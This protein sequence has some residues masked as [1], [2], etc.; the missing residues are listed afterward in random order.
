MVI[1]NSLLRSIADH[2]W[3]SLQDGFLA[4]SAMAVAGLLAIEYDLFRF[5]GEMSRPSDAYRLPRPSP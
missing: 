3:T 1:R 4:L 5:A 2:P